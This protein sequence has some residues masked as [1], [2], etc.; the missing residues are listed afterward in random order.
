M[1][2]DPSTQTSPS[3]ADRPPEDAAYSRDS[4]FE[5]LGNLPEHVWETL[6]SVFEH[7][8][9]IHVTYAVV[10]VQVAIVLLQTLP[11]LFVDLRLFES[12]FAERAGLD[13]EWLPVLTGATRI[14]TTY[15][16]LP[17]ALNAVLYTLYRPIRR[18]HFEGGSAVPNLRAAFGEG[19]PRIFTIVGVLIAWY[20]LSAVGFLFCIL[21]GLLLMSIS[22]VPV[23]IAATTDRGALDVLGVSWRLIGRQWKAI[24]L[25]ALFELV[26]FSFLSSPENFVT[27][28]A[29][30]LLMFDGLW[31]ILLYAAFWFWGPAVML[32]VEERDR[33]IHDSEIWPRPD[34]DGGT[35]HAASPADTPDDPGDAVSNPDEDRTSSDDPFDTDAEW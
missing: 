18:M 3:D 2:D 30:S 15:I 26:A 21:P 32:V 12:L 35:A 6:R 5:N 19:L 14:T 25:I 31:R 29:P 23:Y 4:A 17:A 34:V 7:A 27:C 9:A 16:V 22:W 8:H 10:A 28:G 24:V 1:T 13:G 20:T 33:A 11:E